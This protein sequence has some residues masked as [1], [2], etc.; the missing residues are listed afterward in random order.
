[1]ASGIPKK[2][3]LASPIRSALSGLRWRIRAYI[4]VEGL[5]CAAIW[6]SLIFWLCLV[7][8]YL[9]VVLGASE[10]PWQIRLLFLLVS[11]VA[12]AVIFYRQILRR[13]IVRLPNRSLALL[14]ERRYSEFHDSLLTTV[15]L[16]KPT[17]QGTLANIEMRVHSEDQALAH[18]RDVRL[19]Q[20]FDF[21][22]LYRS[23][24]LSL[25]L[26]AA[27][28][29]F[30]MGA[31]ATFAI[32]IN[33]LYGLSECTWPRRSEIAVIGF[34]DRH[35]K[36]ARGTNYTLE[37]SASAQK[38]VPEFCTIFY[39]S[40][41]ND[42]GRVRMRKQ[43]ILSR[44]SGQEFVYDGVPFNGM[45]STVHFD[46]VGNDH[47]LRDYTVEVVN[48]PTLTEV[49]LECR[50]PDYLV[51]EQLGVYLPRNVRWTPG[52]QLPR[53]TEIS[54]RVTA[55]KDLVEVQFRERDGEQ[56]VSAR[57][58]S[59]ES[60]PREFSFP[61]DA[62]DKDVSYEVTLHD[63][64]GVSN[65]SPFRISIFSLDDLPPQVN[66]RI[67]GISSAVTANA[68]LPFVGDVSDDN[69]LRD[70]WFEFKRLR[71]DSPDVAH[72]TADFTFPLMNWDAGQKSAELD[73]RKQQSERA[74]FDLKP[75]DRIVVVAKA[76][77]H[78]NLDT[79]SNVGSSD[80]FELEVVTSD[81]LLTLLETREIGLRRRLEQILEELTGTRDSL[82]RV[83]LS[84]H[85][86][87]LKPDESS[88]P[89][90]QDPE[91]GAVGDQDAFERIRSLRLLRVQRAL[92]D[93]QRSE[94]EIFGVGVAFDDI[95]MELVNN[96]VDTVKRISRLDEQIAGPL[97][98][99]AVT[100]FPPLVES[101]QL[102]EQRIN[103]EQQS[104]LAENSINQ[105]N[106][107]LLDLDKILSRILDLE[108]YNQLLEIVRAMMDDQDR[109]IDET[110]QRR[111][112]LAVELLE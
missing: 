72:E 19:R 66:L 98:Q 94:S 92:Q 96:R 65:E 8:D 7:L 78:C 46:V 91:D 100:A 13:I 18:L 103:A 51:D 42:R 102:L 84:N 68:R 2:Q 112:E 55:D 49:L 24:A 52:T 101:L 27:I 87:D 89:V 17:G 6:M 107:I 34:K 53:G 32:A 56:V 5:A 82:V 36:V 35:L 67:Q 83:R 79:T 29:F 12:S 64:D 33:R 99:I 61:I 45:L 57:P 80:L 23:M 69:G 73:L 39:R 74:E 62:L 71:R 25:L 75:G 106:Q 110:E 93:V 104:Q 16:G 108:T 50:F 48:S 31:P 21:R 4:V 43:G 15:E 97:K 95:R 3:S 85:G 90:V 38:R 63:T 40:K 60:P 47:R 81:R 59:V 111:D 77:D 44:E 88:P 30:A 54:I 109:L 58:T 26:V 70:A 11:A 20:V 76:A 22:P 9:P 28:V 1:M 86:E 14:L 10:M 105:L 41:D 37:V